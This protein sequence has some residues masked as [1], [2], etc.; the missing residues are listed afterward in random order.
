MNSPKDYVNPTER[1]D[2]DAHFPS[3][4]EDWRR[5]QCPRFAWFFLG[6]F[7]GSALTWAFIYAYH[8]GA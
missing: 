8:L 2:L 5:P 1:L 4:D 3:S 6:G 7:V